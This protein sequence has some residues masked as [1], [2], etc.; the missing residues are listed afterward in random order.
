MF[1]CLELTHESGHWPLLNIPLVFYFLLFFFFTQQMFEFCFCFC[2]CVH[3]FFPLNEQGE[4]V[5]EERKGETTEH[6]TRNHT[7]SR[8][9]AQISLQGW[10]SLP[11]SETTICSFIMKTPPP[12]LSSGIALQHICDPCLHC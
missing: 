6:F 3:F 12:R 10:H 7:A 2:V 9:K 4:V 5:A 1:K 11:A 8:H